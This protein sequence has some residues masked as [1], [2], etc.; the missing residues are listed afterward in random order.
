MSFV[1][2]PRFPICQRYGYTVRS[3]WSETIASAASSRERRNRNWARSLRVFN[4]QMG[5]KLQDEILEVYE[6]WEALA[7]PDCGFRFRDWADYLSC[8]VGRTATPTD[9]PLVVI[10][11]SP[12]GCQL[13]KTYRMGSRATVRDILKPVVGTIR[14]ADNGVEKTEGSQWSLDYTTGLLTLFFSPV[15][16]LSW[17]GEFDVPVRFDSEFPLELSS[18]QVQQVSFQLKELRDAGVED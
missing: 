16:P 18:H 2:D 11:G 3:Q 10:P 14:I 13:Q 5:P 9:Q 6:F 15:Q 1:E 8:R 17:G 4:V 12:G 7:G